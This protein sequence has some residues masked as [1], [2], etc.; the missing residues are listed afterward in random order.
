V[1]VQQRS[2]WIPMSATLTTSFSFSI[3][4]PKIADLCPTLR[5]V[6]FIAQAL[7]STCALSSVHS[8]PCD[9]FVQKVVPQVKKLSLFVTAF[10][11]LYVSRVLFRKKNLN[12]IPQAVHQALGMCFHVGFEVYSST[13]QLLP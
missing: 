13:L 11:D 12:V 7:A 9:N 8:L 6:Y 5:L 2:L 10:K 1:T 4:S 3:S